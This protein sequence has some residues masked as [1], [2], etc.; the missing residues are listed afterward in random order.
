MSVVSASARRR[1]VVVALGVAALALVPVGAEAVVQRVA[2]G[3]V[4]TSGPPDDV[5]RRALAS[6]SVPHVGLAR[7]HGTL[8]LPNLPRLEDV[9]AG[10]G[11]D[12]TARVWWAGPDAWRVD[13][14]GRS[15]ESDSYRTSTGLVRWDYEDYRLTDVLGA[16]PAL[17]PP[18]SDDLLP[19]Q[20]ARRLL[21]GVGA[22]DRVTGL[23]G[24]RRVAGVAADGVRVVP[25]DAR[26]S[27]G[28]LDV[29]VERAHG[30][31]VAVTVADRRGATAFDAR[32]LELDVARPDDDL[33]APPPA[34]DARRDTQTVP[35]LLSR[36]DAG[37]GRRGLPRVLAGLPAAAAL[38]PGVPTFGSGL[39]RLSVVR[40]SPGVAQQSLDAVRQGGGTPTAVPGGA[41]LLAARGVVALGVVRSADGR[42]AYLVAGTVVPDV[43]LAA[44]RR[45]LA[46]A[47][48]T[49]TPSGPAS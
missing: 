20:V 36:L 22:G 27:I 15:G 42:R 7:S 12:S 6:A 35:D 3:G 26:G 14:L 33:L 44:A 46:P 32:Y 28:H 1:W 49:P 4:P 16:D 31:P 38:V 45:L 34:P 19:P 23:P 10:L 18:R 40:I 8:G 17:R 37:R 2:T 30:L 24:P 47:S 25:G 21:A 43:V 13:V 5:M 39:V 9:A 48:P 29:W 11:S 41:V